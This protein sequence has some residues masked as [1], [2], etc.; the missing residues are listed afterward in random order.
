MLVGRTI[1]DATSRGL[2]RDPLAI[3]RVSLAAG[4]NVI[5]GCGYYV[6]MAQSLQMMDKRTEEDIAQEIVSDI[7]DGVEDTG[8]HSGIIGEIGCSWPIE[9]CEM[10]VLRAAGM[11]QKETRAAFYVHPGRSE[12]APAEIT[13][14]LKEIGTD[15][16]RTVICH[17]ERTLFEAKNRYAI[18]NS[19]CYLAYDLWGY[20]GYYPE[21]LTLVDIPNDTMRI[22]QIKDLMARGYGSQILISHDLDAKCR[23]MAYG[24]HGYNHILYNAVPA[25]LRR[26]VTEEQ[27][28]DLL[29]E[30]PKRIL[31]FS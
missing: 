7:F 27:I 5:M 14:I 10:K 2:G 13:K 15:L 29:V 4:L 19:G 20:E 31:P 24:G 26:G 22:A 28:N 8:V 1:V 17:V 11:A 21:S 12:D 9:N 6:E 16:N 25:M 18:A 23:C 3:K 30:N